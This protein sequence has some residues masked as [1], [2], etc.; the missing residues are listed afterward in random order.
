MIV[1]S[2]FSKIIF[3]H[4]IDQVRRQMLRNSILSQ[5]SQL[6]I[7]LRRYASSKS[8]HCR[9]NN[10]LPMDQYKLTAYFKKFCSTT[11]VTVMAPTYKNCGCAKI[12]LW[13]ESKPRRDLQQSSS[14]LQCPSG[15]VSAITNNTFPLFFVSQFQ[16][17]LIFIYCQT[18]CSFCNAL[19]YRYL[20]TVAPFHFCRVGHLIIDQCLARRNG[21][22]SLY[23]A[24]T[25]VFLYPSQYGLPASQATAHCSPRTWM[26]LCGTVPFSIVQHSRVQ[27]N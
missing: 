12:G 13:I 9:R 26:K 7:S 10:F 3:D 8:F 5:N 1:T 6:Y 24:F 20:L 11:E 16:Y 22:K 19:V 15:L 17:D 25:T 2:Y 23:V 21:T 18:W 27:H 4:D 14:C